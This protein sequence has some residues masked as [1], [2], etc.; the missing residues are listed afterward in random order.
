MGSE[1]PTCKVEGTDAFCDRH[2]PAR[3]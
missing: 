2:V 1:A 3:T